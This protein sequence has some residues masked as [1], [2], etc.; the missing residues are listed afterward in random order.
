MLDHV[1]QRRDH[2]Q[3]GRDGRLQGQQGQDPLLDLQI[4]PVD[5]VVVVDDDRR[6]LDVLVLQ[7]LE[8][9]IHRLDD[10]VDPAEGLDLEVAEFLLE[11]LAAAGGSHRQPTLPVTYSSVRGSSGLVKILSVAA[12]STTWPVRCSFSLSCTVKNAVMSDTRAA[13]C[14]LCV[15]ITIE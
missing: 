2:A 1:Q 5:A 15:T 3:V 12:Y 8:R 4:A 10:E 7:S 6:Q 9:P 13:C 11:V 14:M